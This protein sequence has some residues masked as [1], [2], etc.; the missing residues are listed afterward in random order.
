M[1]T[2]QLLG[3]SKVAEATPAAFCR[4][5][6]GGSLTIDYNNISKRGVGG[7]LH[8]RKGTSAITL[9]MSGVVGVAK[10][11][12]VKWFPTTAGAQVAAFPNFLVE[13]V[14]NRAWTLSDGQPAGC[15]ISCGDG[16]D[17]EMEFSMDIMFATAAGGAAETAACVYNTMQGHTRNDI[18]VTGVTNCLSFDIANG[19]TTEMYN[20]MVAKT[21][22]VKTFPDGYA[23][24]A[25][26]PSFSCV[27]GD[28]IYLTGAAEPAF[29]DAHAKSTIVVTAKN[30]TGAEDITIT[31]ADFVPDGSAVVPLEADGITGWALSYVPGDGVSYGRVAIA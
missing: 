13:V 7:Q 18:V 1:Y 28:P 27:S 24:T 8:A 26:A 14:G 3:V 10:T 22:G 21:A 23:I 17:A 16:P 19:L 6:T 20:P 11:D 9:S 2:G 12:I 30:G 4:A 5:I 31:M 25:Q 29:A 15:T